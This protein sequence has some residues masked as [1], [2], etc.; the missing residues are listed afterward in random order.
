MSFRLRVTLLA[1]VAVAA[2]VV[3]ASAVVYVVVR[4]QLLGDVNA[5]L[6]D[7][8][9]DVVHH[10][11]PPGFGIVP[12]GPR[13]SL[14]GPPTYVQ[15]IGSNGE[16]AAVDLPGQAK[17]QDL[18]ARSGRSFYSEGQINDVHV[19]VYAERIGD[20]LAV[21]VARPLNEVDHSL[22]RLRLYLVFIG[23]GGIG[24][25][26]ALGLVVGHVTLRPVGDLTSVAEQVAETR[27]LSRRIQAGSRDELGR[28]ASSFNSM[29]EA[30]DESQKAQRQL[31]ADASHELR[32]PLASVRTNI[33]V[34]AGGKD[35]PPGE[36]RKLLADV[37]GQV[38]ELSALVAALVEVDPDAPPE[39]EDVRLD[40]LVASAVERA[41]LHSPDVDFRTAL[42]ASVV[43]AAPQ[44]LERALSNLLDNAAKWSD[45]VE[46][47]VAGPEVTVRDYGPGI[48]DE[49]LPKIFDRFYRAAAARHLPGSGLGLAIVRQVAR[50]HGGDVTAEN[51]PGGGAVF[52]LRLAPAG[53]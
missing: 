35:L 46:I 42:E 24:L 45:S 23:L 12:V 21:Q 49:D 22:H 5:S 31:I 26:S 14:G 4:H 17:A 34:L 7:R 10:P 11:G 16:G 2:A 53:G 1:T 50:S 51:A 19:R 20:G 15:V 47:R 25:A 37:I 44:Q 29:L 8:A 39:L 30:L 18:A 36:H 52:R 40:E 32:T 41:H 38:E 13:A 48:A 3:A 27:D 43:R 9:R 33:E 6:V 28:L